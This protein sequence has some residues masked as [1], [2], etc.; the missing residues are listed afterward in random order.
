MKRI[1]LS[2]VAICAAI[3][4]N[5]QADTLTEYFTGTPTLYAS[6]AGYVC[7]NNNYG[8][9]AKYQRFDAST[10]INTDGTVTGVLLWVGAKTDAGGSFDVNVVDFAGGAMGTILG[11]ETITLASIDT[12]TAGLALAEGAVGYNVA[13]TFAT[14]IAFT[15]ASDLAI[16]VV[17]PTTAGDTLG[18]V[19]NTDLD[20]T[21]AATHSFELWSD[22]SVNYI[23]DPNNW[24]LGI[25]MAIYPVVDFAASLTEASITAKVYPNPASTVLN[26]NT[27]SVATSVSVL[28]LDGKV[29]SNTVMNG[30]STSVNVAELTAGVYFYE[31]I[32]EDGS[33]LRDTF[34]KK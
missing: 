28:S 30:T 2:V 24:D 13:V 11:S 31:I 4:V 10:G 32:A 19:S 25:A 21:L 7:G 29:I 16:G 33:V 8:D 1:L 26:V 6:G 17:L 14:P 23:G 34:V 15:A 27:T 9:L 3:T 20:F 12:T 5:A 22:G 18:L